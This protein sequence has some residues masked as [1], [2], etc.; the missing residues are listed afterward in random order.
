VTFERS[1]GPGGWEALP[2]LPGI[3]LA[4]AFVG[5]C[6]NALVVAGGAN[7][8]DKPPW[9]G[10]VKRWHADIWMLDDPAGQWVRAGELPAPRAY[11]ATNQAD[12]QMLCVGGSDADRHYADAWKLHR[13]G[14]KRIVAEKIGELPFAVANAAW[15]SKGYLLFV[16]GGQ[17]ELSS[18]SARRD[19]VV[20]KTVDGRLECQQL[21]MLPGD[22][23][24]LAW[25]GEIDSGWMVGGGAAL[26]AGTDGKPMR[27]LLRDN[28]RFDIRPGRWRRCSDLPQ[29]VVA[30]PNPGLAASGTLTVLPGDDGSRSGFTPPDKHPGF[31]ARGWEYAIREDRWREV[32][33]LP[34]AQVTTGTVR[35]RGLWV[36]ASGEI[37]PGVRTAA[38][39]GHR[40][41]L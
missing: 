7:F 24:I 12:G 8:P 32:E 38:V 2:P 21:P 28:W 39:W 5:V 23:R 17:S 29:P 30:P 20:A 36:V 14:G 18:T 1:H 13:T 16:A 31:P 26:E 3:G 19:A 34:F 33:P 22:G 4:G 35:W 27:R 6:G 41:R 15:A 9:D 11:G 40:L 25:A 10:G 37:R